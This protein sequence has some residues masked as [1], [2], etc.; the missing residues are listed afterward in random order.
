MIDPDGVRVELI[1]SRR[2]F[3]DYTADRDVY[4]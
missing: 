3:G 4:C 1:Q 2:G